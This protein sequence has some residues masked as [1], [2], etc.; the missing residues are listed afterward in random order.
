MYVI[1]FT[2]KE[3]GIK[4]FIAPKVFSPILMFSIRH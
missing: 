3:I 2:F 1:Y 4:I